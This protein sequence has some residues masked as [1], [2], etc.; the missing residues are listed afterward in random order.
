MTLWGKFAETFDADTLRNR[1]NKE[2]VFVLFLGVMVDQ[3]AGTDILLFIT[4]LK[5]I[6]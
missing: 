4:W 1:S 3:Y 2:P 6:S 5:P